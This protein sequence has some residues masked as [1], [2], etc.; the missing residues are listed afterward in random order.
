MLLNLHSNYSLRYGTL[1]IEQL[2]AN[3]LAGGY[4]TAVLTDINNSSATLDFIKAC[5]DKGLNGLAGME[6][7]N[8]DELL[9][10]G[11]AKNT[12]GFRE[13]NELMTSA[14]R[15][16]I[17]L[18]ARAPE[19]QQAFVVYPFGK[20]KPECLRENEFIGIK[21]RQFN[22][23]VFAPGKDLEKYVMLHP[24]SFGKRDYKLHRQLRAIDHNLLISQLQPE[25]FALE[26]E[27]MIPK[28]K[29]LKNFEQFP[30]L[31]ANT[32]KLL[33]QCTFDFDFKAVRNKQSFT[34][35]RYDDKNLLYKYAMDGLS[36]RYDKS[37]KA[38][39]E[40]VMKELEIIDNLNFSAYF[41]ITDDICRYARNRN[42]LM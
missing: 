22:K 39:R 34:G 20:I 33:S 19:F 28:A 18:P 24:V 14:N 21:A 38:A 29:L 35:N 26:D 6:Y 23:I 42:F 13:L 17:L 3:M 4:D 10:I 27:I 37:D 8:G 12:E 36:R 30:Q 15:D 41:L 25:Q 7:R 5:K 31:I 32:W 2:A 11:I 1:S 9:Y 40:R 16:K